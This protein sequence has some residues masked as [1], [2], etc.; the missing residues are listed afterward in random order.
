MRNTTLVVA[1][2]MATL[3]K[4]A[5]AQTC[6]TATRPSNPAPTT[7]LVVTRIAGDFSL[8]E[9]R[10]REIQIEAGKSCWLSAAGCPRMGRIRVAIVDAAGKTV[11]EEVGYSP[12]LCFSAEQ[13]GKYTVKVAALSLRSGYGWGSID[14]GLSDSNCGK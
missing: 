4:G 10:T 2:V 7:Q 11:K 9:E 1:M 3:A 5:S 8:N 13:S 6:H 14:A 12:S